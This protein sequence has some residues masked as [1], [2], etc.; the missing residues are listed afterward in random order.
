M[1]ELSQKDINKLYK[2]YT[3]EGRIEFLTFHPS[4]SYEDFIEGLTVSTDEESGSLRYEIKS[5]LFKKLCTKALLAA[6]GEKWDLV[7]EK[8]VWKDVYQEYL[9]R[10]DI[11][12]EKI[13]K[14]ILI[15]DEI[16]RGDMAKILGELI[17]LL[18]ADKRLGAGT[19]RFSC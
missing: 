19:K 2:E 17:T 4:Y 3:N 15:I 18:E 13:P 14:F 7:P 16:N 1:A 10:K 12:W 11:I 5:G 8:L 6:M 9:R